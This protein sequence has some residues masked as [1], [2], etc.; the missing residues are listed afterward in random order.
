MPKE[1]LLTDPEAVCEASGM[2]RLH[3][4]LDI[5]GKTVQTGCTADML[6]TV[7]EI[8]AYANSGEINFKL[9]QKD[10]AINALYKKYSALNPTKIMDFDGYRIEFPTWWFSV[11][12]SNTEPYL[13][14]VAEAKTEKELEE[15][16]ADLK[17]II[18]QFS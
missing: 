11:R 4:H 15:R 14:I 12:K 5:N 1:K 6:Y 8:I 18:G 10:E 16:L 2:Q 7:D 3:F 9:E 17:A 13:R